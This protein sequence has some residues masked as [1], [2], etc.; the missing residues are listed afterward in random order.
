MNRPALLLVGAGGHAQSCIDV[1]EREGRFDIAGLIGLPQEFGQEVMGYRVMGT[2]DDLANLRTRV[3]HAL[4]TIGQ[5]YPSN[6]RA[7]LYEK[8]L[9]L[10]YK[11][12]SICSPHAVV[13]HHVQLG[14][15]TIAMHGVVINAGAQI[16][17]NCIIN[18]N[19]LVE[20]GVEV[21][22]HCHL[23]TAVVVNGGACVGAYTTVGSA[24]IVREGVR[25]GQ[26]ALIGMG[27]VVRHDVSDN[28]HIP[29]TQARVSP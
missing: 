6:R 29:H 9:A 2:D 21:G 20:H 14:N 5:I 1:I 17:A 23:A 12:P 10:G 11:L 15:G 24:A 25:I 7:Q 19:A 13:S 16:G 18:T 4:V 28:E 22:D 8:L 26:Y 3:S 27:S